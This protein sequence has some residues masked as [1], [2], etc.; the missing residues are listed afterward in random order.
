MFR[1]CLFQSSVICI[2]H[3][4]LILNRIR[5]LF[6]FERHWI[7]NICALALISNSLTLF[8]IFV[9][10]LIFLRHFDIL[11][12]RLGFIIKN[13]C[14]KSTV[15]I[16]TGV[17]ACFLWHVAFTLHD[18]IRYSFLQSILDGWHILSM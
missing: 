10:H 4:F 18:T 15:I 6:G 16:R 13:R 9:R 2:L 8:C 12:C 7:L 11:M 3:C 1:F 14:I 5:I 17:F